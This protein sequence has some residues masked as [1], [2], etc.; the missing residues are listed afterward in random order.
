MLPRE[1]VK[2]GV[3][4]SFLKALLKEC[5]RRKV[6]VITDQASPHTAKETTNFVKTQSRLRLFYLPAYSPDY[7]ADEKVW[8]HL[9]NRQMAAHRATDDTTLRKTTIRALRSMQARPKLVRS[10]YKR[11]RISESMNS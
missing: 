1:R 11:S 6:F 7:N 8:D 4:V 3:F 2:A 10:F 5:P 9:K